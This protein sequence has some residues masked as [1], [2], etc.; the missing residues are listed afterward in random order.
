MG[1]WGKFE[2]WFP[3]GLRQDGRKIQRD[4]EKIQ[5]ME[6]LSNNRDQFRLL[7]AYTMHLEPQGK[8]TFLKT[9]SGNKG[10]IK[11]LKFLHLARGDANAR[12]IERNAL[13]RR[14]AM[15]MLDQKMEF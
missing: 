8:P 1:G 15:Q 5:G 14:A 11:K 13:G 3:N 7:K 9:V 4:F 10:L 12:L 6:T 2:S